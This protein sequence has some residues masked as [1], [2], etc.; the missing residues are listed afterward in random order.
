MLSL[1]SFWRNG[2][3]HPRNHFHKK[4]I[5]K[6]FP[7]VKKRGLVL[8]I[9]DER[10]TEITA[11]FGVSGRYEPPAVM[12]CEKSFCLVF[13]FAIEDA[14]QS[15]EQFGIFC[16]PSISAS[17]SSRKAVTSQIKSTSRHTSKPTLIEVLD[18]WIRRKSTPEIFWSILLN[19]IKAYNRVL[20]L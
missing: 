19:W 20:L 12:L 13:W 15:I 16:V 7:K 14:F 11:R 10:D 9:V 17:S 2:K 8:K 1:L 6:I 4:I 18:F 3:Y 5:P